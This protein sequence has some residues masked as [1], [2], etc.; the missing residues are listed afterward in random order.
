MFY[1]V[2]THTSY[3]KQCIIRL[4]CENVTGKKCKKNH[5]NNF[6][7]EKLVHIALH[8]SQFVLTYFIFMYTDGQSFRHLN[9]T[10]SPLKYMQ[11]VKIKQQL[12]HKTTKI[13]CY[14]WTHK[15]VELEESFQEF[16][17]S[18]WCRLLPTGTKWDYS[19]SLLL[20]P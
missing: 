5:N 6:C 8:I 13:W 3:D 4:P 1:K 15:W 17:F 14:S 18:S 7:A 11:R 12:F 10:C 16:T 9:F 19:H 2:F 20:V